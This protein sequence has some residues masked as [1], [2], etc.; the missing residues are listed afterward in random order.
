MIDDIQQPNIAP[1]IQAGSSAFE[2]TRDADEFEDVCTY[3]HID[4]SQRW[5]Q[6]LGFNNIQ[7]APL[8]C[9]PHAENFSC[10]AHYHPSG[11]YLTF[12]Q[13]SIYN[14]DGDDF[15]DVDAAEDAEVV[16]HE[17]GHA[18]NNSI[19]PGWGGGDEGAMGEGW[20][21]YWAS[22]YSRSVSAYE[23]AWIGDWGLRECFGG[24]S[25]QAGLHYPED[26]GQEVHYS[27]EIWSQALYDAEV[28]IN[29][30]TVMNRVS[31]QS[32][33][34]YGTG[35]SMLTA[36]NA[37]L[38]ADQNLYG[39]SHQ[40]GITTSFVARGLI[41]PPNNDQCPGFTI[42]DL[43]Y[44]TNGSTSTAAH[45]YDNCAG[46]LSQD[47]VY[48][49]VA[50]PCPREITVSI[51]GGADYDT[52]LTIR[53]GGACPGNTQV[54]CNDDFC[55]LQSQLT[56]TTVANQAYYIIVHGYQTQSGTFNISVTGFDSD[57]LPPNDACVGALV[58]NTL[59]YAHSSTTCGA[60][61]NYNDC[62]GAA[63][64]E[65]VY[66]LN[67]PTCQSVT[68]S[69]CGSDYDTAVEVR[70]GG[71]CPGSQTIACN[72]DYC[73]L[74]SQVTFNATA[75]ENYYIF[76]HGYCTNC[77]GPYALNVTSN[78]P[79]AIPNDDCP[80]TLITSLPYQDAGNTTCAANDYANCIG[81][82]SNDVVYR[83]T[84]LDCEMVTVS[85]CGSAYD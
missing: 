5:M 24:R 14:P 35:A 33:Y 13:G 49:L 79:V 10:N 17:Y 66:R 32:Y 70:W 74:S 44:V 7:N 39:G 30:R 61:N 47:V 57:P 43:P 62:I 11:N 27:G 78:G 19:T 80:G 38:T 46:N 42:Y 51:C 71:N 64:P 73:G 83:Y 75:N 55:G 40:A 37:V 69:L 54:V 16:L 63:S 9:D 53:T 67:V 77:E 82:N 4:Q 36:A 12:G 76:V 22:S 56:F 59:P 85:L 1:V 25:M 6:T 20:G 26:A 72:D 60:T 52:Y 15:P 21:D 18:I 65:T 45:N 2:Y 31:L 29:N 84:P 48:T 50:K 34:Y 23:A 28:N 81:T 68:V 3:Y 58:I 8:P 41:T